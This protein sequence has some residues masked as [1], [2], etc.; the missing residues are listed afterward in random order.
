MR[1]S[2][3]ISAVAFA[4][5]S[6]AES[7][8]TSIPYSN[9]ATS[10]LTQTDSNGVITG[11]P[12][13]ATSMPGAVTTQP[14]VVTSQPDAA[15]I[16]ALSSGMNTVVMGN[17]T[18][19]YNVVNNSTVL[20]TPTPTAATTTGGSGSGSGSGSSGSK[21][22]SGSSSTSSGAADNIKLASGALAG[23][24]AVFALFL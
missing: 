13:V 22:G 6:V 14:G 3:I 1:A 12:S 24:G 19:T 8:V 15:S 7:S 16:P 10:Y 21:T 2:T 18:Q 4:A 5:L 17:R 23:A 20:V 9:P 11:Q